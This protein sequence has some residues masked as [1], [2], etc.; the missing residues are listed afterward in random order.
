MIELSYYQNLV[1]HAKEHK[2]AHIGN[3]SVVVMEEI[4]KELE[5]LREAVLEEW[6]AIHEHKPFL[7][8]CWEWDG[9]LIDR[10]DPEFSCCKCYQ[11]REDGTPIA[12]EET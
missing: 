4:I 2:K 3:M 1:E 8:Y 7:H 12:P 11:R 5:K 6:K 10:C 9:L